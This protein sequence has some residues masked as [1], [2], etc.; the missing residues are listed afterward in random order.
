MALKTKY[1]LGQTTTTSTSTSST[2]TST[3]STTST[4]TIC[5]DPLVLCTTTTANPLPP[6]VNPIDFIF[7]II[8]KFSITNGICFK[9][10]IKEV[11]DNGFITNDCNVCCPD[12]TYVLADVITFLKYADAV[13][14]LNGSLPP[15][16]AVE[17]TGSNASDIDCCLNNFGFSGLSENLE[18]VG[19]E[20]CC[21]NFNQC[22]YNIIQHFAD[23]NCETGPTGITNLA[24]IIK[25]LLTWD[26]D[27]NSHGGIVE[28]GAFDGNSQLC[29]ILENFIKFSDDPCFVEAF[30]DLL[31]TG[32]VIECFDGQVFIGSIDLYLDIIGPSST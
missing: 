6:C 31:T 5:C 4:T 14:N 11:L 3:T 9:D 29:L 19:F 2:T 12:C 23:N 20:T 17:K 15:L 22:V 24:Q 8:N 10:S 27:I 21:N 26:G 28:Q 18:L 7:D 30:F 1:S 13:L 25:R 16:G 32:L